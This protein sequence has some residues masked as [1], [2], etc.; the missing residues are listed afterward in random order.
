MPPRPE[1]ESSGGELRP[2]GAVSMTLTWWRG[3]VA[4]GSERHVCEGAQICTR[5]EQGT[6]ACAA[7]PEGESIS[8]GGDG[9]R[10]GAALVACS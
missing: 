5:A 3:E 4:G 1:G 2:Q 8:I 9:W 6:A 10:A 7:Q